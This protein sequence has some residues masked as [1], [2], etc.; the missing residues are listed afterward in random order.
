MKIKQIQNVDPK[1]KLLIEQLLLKRQ[2]K[3]LADCCGERCDTEG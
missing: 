2:S 3:K 1:K